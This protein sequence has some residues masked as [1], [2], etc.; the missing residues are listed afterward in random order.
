M[1]I[2]SLNLLMDLAVSKIYIYDF[3]V[4]ETPSVSGLSMPAYRGL[5]RPALG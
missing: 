4:K 3:I 5:H 1:T 2:S